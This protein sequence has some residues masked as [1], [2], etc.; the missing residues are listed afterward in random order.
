MA[1]KFGVEEGDDIQSLCLQPDVATLMEVKSGHQP[2][3]AGVGGKT[4]LLR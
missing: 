4:R 3:K 1:E 2:H